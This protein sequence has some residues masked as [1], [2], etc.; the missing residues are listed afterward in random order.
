MGS[1]I[2]KVINTTRNKSTNVYSYSI[3]EIDIWFNCHSKH[4]GIARCITENGTD[5]TDSYTFLYTNNYKH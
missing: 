4:C 3:T 1:H 2:D 5:N